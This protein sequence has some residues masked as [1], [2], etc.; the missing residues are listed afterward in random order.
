MGAL[1][2]QIEQRAESMPWL[3][4]V[5]F[6][7]QIVTYGELRERIGVYGPVATSHGM[8]ANAALSAALISFLPDWVRV[9]EPNEQA[10]WISQSILWLSRGL[11]DSSGPLSSAV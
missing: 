4:A 7:G 2:E 6:D 9:L 10:K 3:A 5:R 8:S 1:L 11:S